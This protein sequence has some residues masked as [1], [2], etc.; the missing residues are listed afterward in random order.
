VYKKML[1]ALSSSNPEEVAKLILEGADFAVNDYELVEAAA[2][3]G[4][5]RILS[6]LISVYP[7][8][9]RIF[10]WGY[11]R[12]NGTLY[13]FCP[14]RMLLKDFVKG[15]PERSVGVLKRMKDFM[16]GHEMDEIMDGGEK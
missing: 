12:E 1:D 16:K 2:R 8:C 13:P 9:G 7:E 5:H 6:I 4:N 3:M 10:R 11:G 14:D 15:L